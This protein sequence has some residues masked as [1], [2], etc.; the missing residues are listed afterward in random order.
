MTSGGVHFARTQTPWRSFGCLVPHADGIPEMSAGR[1]AIL[2]NCVPGREG[3][4]AWGLVAF[5]RKLQLRS[6]PHFRMAF[7]WVLICEQPKLAGPWETG[8][9]VGFPA[10]YGTRITVPA[11]ALKLRHNYSISLLK[12]CF[13]ICDFFCCYR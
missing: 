2:S 3:I 11:L 10:V 13:P 5:G 8:Q 7:T 1:V 6:G 4:S 12:S 9:R